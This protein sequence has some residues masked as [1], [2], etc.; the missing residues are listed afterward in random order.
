[1]Y[2]D[3]QGNSLCKLT[4]LFSRDHNLQ[5]TERISLKASSVSMVTEVSHD[6]CWLVEPRVERERHLE[7]NAGISA[8]HC[9]ESEL[10]L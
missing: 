2:K 1:M 10:E 6:P 5:L 3:Q 8:D 4:I 7:E 9:Q